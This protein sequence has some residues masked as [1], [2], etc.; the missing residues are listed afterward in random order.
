MATTYTLQVPTLE[1]YD[2]KL[3]RIPVASL[4]NFAV[5]S[6]VSTA[7]EQT[8]TYTYG[9]GD[10]ADVLQLIVKRSY[11]AKRDV[12]NCSMRLA[13]LIKKSVSETGAIEYSPIDAVLAWN[14]TGKYSPDATFPVIMMSIGMS[15]F[16]QELTGANGTPTSLVV[17]KFDHNTLLEVV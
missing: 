17:S 12:T 10:A 4:S 15:I 3:R 8:V 9:A 2:L 11:N 7:D 6:Q 5:T 1:D 13:G 16:A 14:I